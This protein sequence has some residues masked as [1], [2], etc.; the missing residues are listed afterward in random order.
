MVESAGRGRVLPQAD[1]K[2][3]ISALPEITRVLNP[4]ET[5]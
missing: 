5:R 1:G 3:I 2:G 4:L